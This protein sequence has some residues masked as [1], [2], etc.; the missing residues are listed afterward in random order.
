MKGSLLSA[1]VIEFN[2]ID[3]V[4]THTTYIVVEEKYA[5][6][7][8]LLIIF[9]NHL[10]ICN[11]HL[12]IP[13]VYILFMELQYTDTIEK[14]WMVKKDVSEDTKFKLRLEWQEN[15]GHVSIT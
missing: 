9:L 4:S 2:K 14:T 8:I 15:T 1:A 3:K 5:K 6:L 12:R 13:E 11:K 10:E 7:Y